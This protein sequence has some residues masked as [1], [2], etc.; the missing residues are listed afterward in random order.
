MVSLINLFVI[1][2]SL[3]LGGLMCYKSGKVTKIDIVKDISVFEEYG[4]K[5]K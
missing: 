3:L 4:I 5:R 2:Y 1:K